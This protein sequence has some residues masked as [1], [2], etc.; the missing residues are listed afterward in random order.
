MRPMGRIEGVYAL[1]FEL[2]R[3]A[4]FARGEVDAAFRRADD[5]TFVWFTTRVTDPLERTEIVEFNIGGHEIVLYR[6]GAGQ[7]GGEVFLVVVR[8]NCDHHSVS[9]KLVLELQ[10]S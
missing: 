6:F 8:K 7:V 5:I 10:G 3:D 1:G 9:A 4:M 2:D